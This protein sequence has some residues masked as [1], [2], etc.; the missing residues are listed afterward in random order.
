MDE[1]GPYFLFLVACA[2]FLVGLV[3]LGDVS[4]CGELHD[5]AEGF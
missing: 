2:L 4:A 1:G 5:D 3:Q